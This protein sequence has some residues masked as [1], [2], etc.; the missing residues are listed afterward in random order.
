M[1]MSFRTRRAA[2]AVALA[3][4]TACGVARP[5]GNT[6]ADS[7]FT[8][9]ARAIIDDHLVRHPSQATDLGVHRFDGRLEDAS[10]AAVQTES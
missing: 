8:A 6:A 7:A 10:A 3:G 1:T 4:L 5:S 9:L 2:L